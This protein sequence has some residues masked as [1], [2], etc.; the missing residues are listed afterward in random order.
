ME[1]KDIV[2]KETR[3]T[4]FQYKNEHFHTTFDWVCGGKG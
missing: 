3:D 2:G 1:V 4:N